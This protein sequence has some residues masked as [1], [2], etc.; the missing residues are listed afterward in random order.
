MS[1]SQNNFVEKTSLW[2]DNCMF[3]IHI[4]Y[5]DFYMVNKKLNFIYRKYI[6]IILYLGGGV[7]GLSL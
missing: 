4:Y 1:W 2:Y 5:I 7:W 3:N 6:L